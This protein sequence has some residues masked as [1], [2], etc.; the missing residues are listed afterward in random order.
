MDNFEIRLLVPAADVVDLADLACFEYAAN[1]GA[2]IP[3]VEP[4]ANLLAI[5]VDR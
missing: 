4:V 3:D 2:V 1:G 5:A